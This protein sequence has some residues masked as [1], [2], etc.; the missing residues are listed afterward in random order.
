MP[1]SGAA[2]GGPGGSPS[3]DTRSR[4]VSA[5]EETDLAQVSAMVVRDGHVVAEPTVFTPVGPTAVVDE[6]PLELAFRF[7]RISVDPARYR[8]AFVYRRD[9]TVRGRFFAVFD[10]G[11]SKRIRHQ[12]EGAQWTLTIHVHDG[13]PL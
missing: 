7:S 9:G 4:P 5:A 6:H 2:R 13:L 10:K 3:V 12:V 8:A 1:S 11:I